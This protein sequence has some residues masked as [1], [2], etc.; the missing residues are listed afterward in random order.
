MD[1]TANGVPAAA[2]YFAHKAVSPLVELGA[3]EWLWL[4]RLDSLGSYAELARSH[5]GALPSDFIGDT[6]ARDTAREAIAHLARS[7]AGNFGI[8]VHGTIE[9]PARLLDAAEQP[10]LLWYQGSWDLVNAPRTV[11][12]VGTR[13]I[14]EKGIRRT[15]KLVKLL[16][17]HNCVVFSGLARGVNAVAHQAAIDLGGATVGI[18][19]TPISDFDPKADWRLQRQIAAEHLL[20]SHVPVLRYQKK[21]SRL[22]RTFLAERSR[23]MS[24][25][26][27]A[28]IIVEAGEISGT[29]VQAQAA[30]DQGRKLFILNSC[31]DKPGLTWPAKM[32]ALGGIRVLE[33]EQI[34]DAV[35]V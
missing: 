34:L 26:V 15:R 19:A 22:Q 17:Q 9:Y 6:P 24:A 33:Y 27:S 28:T 20:I 21:E 2:T 29:I 30:L 3:Y 4:N 11:S 13:E 14:T 5:P 18:A 25:L 12:V 23:T 32:E 16:V 7:G 8:R 31:F 10:G 1:R 35:C